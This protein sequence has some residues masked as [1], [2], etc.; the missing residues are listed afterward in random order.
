MQHIFYILAS[1]AAAAMILG[2]TLLTVRALALMDR[3][4]NTRRD[5]ADLIAESGL[6]LQHANRLLARTQEGVDR[7][8]HAMDRLEG[9]LSMMQPAVAVSGFLAGAKRMVSGRRHAADSPTSPE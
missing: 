5:L 9:L 4:E 2:V 7:V 1:I 6:S 8:R 3:M